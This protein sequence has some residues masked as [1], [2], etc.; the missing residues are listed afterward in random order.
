MDN[1]FNPKDVERLI[2][3]EMKVTQMLF[4]HAFPKMDPPEDKTGSILKKMLDA[5]ET[6]LPP[7]EVAE[8]KRQ[9]I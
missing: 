9:E 1:D 8:K 2:H 5:Y 4:G 7:A 6:D 3:K